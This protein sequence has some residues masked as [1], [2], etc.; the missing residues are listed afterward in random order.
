MK[1]SILVVEDDVDIRSSVVEILEMEGFEV[2][3]ANNGADALQQLDGGLRPDLIL[4]DLMM[5]V[6]DGF[7]FHEEFSRREQFKNVPV[8]VM[9]ADGQVQQKMARMGG[10]SYLKKPLDIEDLIQ[11]IDRHLQAVVT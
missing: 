4:L 8:V 3:S 9:S 6:M 11:T 1:K 7:S 10:R 5:P 2:R